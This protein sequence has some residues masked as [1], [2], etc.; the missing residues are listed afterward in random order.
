M[1]VDQ[2]TVSRFAENLKSRGKQPA[3]VESYCR[4]AQRFLEYLTSNHLPPAGVEPETLVSYQDFLRHECEE[5]DNSIRRSV[6]GV[7]QFFRFLTE[8]KFIQSTPFDLVAIPSRDE[9]L[10][11]GLTDDDIDSLLAVAAAGYPDIK[12]TRDVALVSLLAFEGL[13]ANELINLF[14]SDFL[15]TEG[16]GSL[17]IAG[18]KARSVRLSAESNAMLMRYRDAYHALSHPHLDRAPTKQ[19]FIAF[20]GRDAASPLPRMTR[21]GLKFILYELGEKSG[22]QHLNTEQLRHYAVTYLMALG[23]SPEEIM[24]HLGL[25]RLG[26]IAK[27][28]AEAKHSEPV[29]TARA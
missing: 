27:H 12:G 8:A 18:T 23:R 20:K 17:R 6:I 21:H 7:R 15:V 22:L 5:R 14:W 3:T 24:L 25:R 11:R 19:M 16:H 9:S 10:P 29:E 13:K 26:N 28:F 2:D 1:L 4:D